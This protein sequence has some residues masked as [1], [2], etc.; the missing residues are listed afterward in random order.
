VK[1]LLTGGQGQVGTALAR[2]AAPDVDLV[3]LTH[4][5]LDIADDAAV[6]Q[7]LQRV[8]PDVVINAAA[9]TAVDRAE[10]DAARAAQVNETGPA[11]LARAAQQVGAR[12]IHL[13]TDFVFDGASASPYR[14]DHATRP[15]SVYGATKLA[16]EVAVRN[17]L[18]THSVVLRT[19]W[20]YAASG[21]N[22]MRTML[23]LMQEKG[24]VRVVADQIGT[25]T[26]A[27]SIA[28]CIWK[29][30]AQPA[31]AGVYHWTDAGVASWYDFA[32]AIAEE[33]AAAGILRAGIDVVPI[34]T[35]EYP[36]LARRPRFSV[37]D[38]EA[39]VAAIGLRPAHWRV[40]LRKVLEE[41]KVA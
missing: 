23:R 36:A 32:V 1:V 34:S 13:S 25:P 33:A 41:L 26:A 17:L 14:A 29:I 3:V 4:Q 30:A 37:L 7:A 31:L 28:E 19:A 11:S 16:G 9:Y 40:N 21:H 15:L 35:A 38:K 6:H 27:G 24:S 18:P 39:T 22:F 2:C 8:R 20:V 5:D 12:L 10:T